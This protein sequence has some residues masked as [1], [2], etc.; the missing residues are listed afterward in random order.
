MMS[1]SFEGFK[2]TVRRTDISSRKERIR[3]PRPFYGRQRKIK[4]FME[5]D[6]FIISNVMIQIEQG[7][8]A[9]NNFIEMKLIKTNKSNIHFLVLTEEQLLFIE[10]NQKTLVWQ[11]DT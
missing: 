6:A 11:I 4:N 7:K 1:K 2:N 10:A 3:L 5:N 8:F 9:D